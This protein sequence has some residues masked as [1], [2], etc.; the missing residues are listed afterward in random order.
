VRCLAAGIFA[1]VLVGHPLPARAQYVTGRP[2]DLP[3]GFKIIDADIVVPED[4][5]VYRG[6]YT[7]TLW[8]A[9][10]VPYELDSSVTSDSSKVDRILLAMSRWE[11]VAHVDFVPRS[12]E[13]DY[14]YIQVA[15]FNASEGVGMAGDRHDIWLADWGTDFHPEHELGHALAFWHE[16][17]R[18]DRD[19]YVEIEWDDIGDLCGSGT[20]PCDSQFDY[21]D[22][23]GGEYGPY[24]FDSVMHYG[25][26]YF[27]NCTCSST[28][29]TIT[30]LSPNEAWQTLIGQRDHLSC[31]DQLVMSFLYPESDW[32]FLDDTYSFFEFGTFLYPFNDFASAEAAT[33]AGGTLWILQPGTYAAVGVHCDAMTIEAPLGGVVLCD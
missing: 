33:P 30:V 13:S 19:T 3:A 17:S 31:W 10:D 1:L 8:P 16:Q 29:R 32:V 14:L 11:A 6:T 7:T 24:D 5:D 20:D 25:E 12:G 27:V 22:A 4:F 9:G 2:P 23:P 21:R 15:T 26:C 18:L 28:C